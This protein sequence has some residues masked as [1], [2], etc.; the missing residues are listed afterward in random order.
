M[1]GQ[2]SQCALCNVHWGNVQWVG[3]LRRKDRVMAVIR[4]MMPSFE[5]FQPTSVDDALAILDEHGRDAWVM[6]GGQDSLDW[7]KDRAR[8]PRALVDLGPIAS[9]PGFPAAGH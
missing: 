6:A 1:A 7:F 4:D 5:L 9:L 2:R 3:D 8:R